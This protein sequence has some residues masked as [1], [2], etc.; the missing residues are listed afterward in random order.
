MAE[1]EKQRGFNTL[2][3]FEPILDRFEAV[4]RAGQRPELGEYL[5]SVSEASRAALFCELLSLEL[6]YR[7]DAGETPQV[8]DYLARFPLFIEPIRQVFA[9]SVADKRPLSRR[10]SS[11]QLGTDRNLLFGIMAL[12]MDFI[13]R[14][15]LIE[16]LRDWTTQKD[17]PLGQILVERGDLSAPRRDLLE[18]LVEEHVRQHDNDPA[19][20][21]ASISSVVDADIDWQNVADADIAA[22]LAARRNSRSAKRT[23][24]VNAEDA[25]SSADRFRVLRPHARGGIGEVFLAFDQE[26]HREVALKEIQSRHVRD[27]SHRERFVREAEVT[28]GLEHPGI[29]PVYSLG[30]YG[31]GRPFYAMR[32]IRGDSLKE[33]IEQFHANRSTGGSPVSIEGKEPAQRADT[34]APTVIGAAPPEAQVASPASDQR[35]PLTT[36]KQFESI[37]FRKLLG[38]F[39]DV[40]QSIEYAHSRGVLHRDLKPGNIM[41]G[42]Y[43][44]TLVVDWGLAKAA[45]KDDR[46]ADSEEATFI[47]SSGSGLEQTQQ[48]SIVGTPSYMSPEQ[49]AGK[50]DQLGPTTDVYSLGATLY[51][52][53][54]GQAPVTAQPRQP[55]AANAPAPPRQSMTELLRRVQHGEFPRPREIISHVPNPLEAVCLK[56]MSLRPQDRYASSAALAE[57]IEHWLADEPLT[58]YRETPLATAS[59]WV[60]KHRAWAMSGAA[61]MALVA[62][63]SSVAAVWI[64]SARATVVSAQK[65]EAKQL[66]IA[67]D[68]ERLAIA[69]QKKAVA[70]AVA[71][72]QQ[73]R[74]AEQETKRAND[75]ADRGRLHLYAARMNLVQS[76]WDEARVGETERLLTLYRP[77]AGQQNHSVELRGFEWFYWDRL[78]RS[79]LLTLDGHVDM[80]REVV[81]STDGKLLA[82]ASEDK[83][84]KVWDAASGREILTLKGHTDGVNSVAFSGDGKRLA[85]A[86]ANFNAAIPGEAKVWDTTS[87]H[88]LFTLKGHTQGVLCVAFRADGKQLATASW[89]Q[90]VK[91]WDAT[92]GQEKLT[93]KG[94]TNCVTRVAFSADGERL[95]SASWDRSVKV[96]NP[97]SGQEMLTLNDHTGNVSSVAFSSDRKRL[98]SATGL[99]A[100]V[101]DATNGEEILTLKG[102][103]EGVN[104]VTFSSDGNRLATASHD[105]TVKVWD[106]TSG[107]ESFTL[108]GHNGPILSVAFN[109]NDDRL[110]SAG[111]DGAVKVWDATSGQETLTFRGHKNGATTLAFSPNGKQI[112]SSGVGATVILW[113]ASSGQ[114]ILSLKGHNGQVMSVAFSADGKRLLSSD[115]RGTMKV[116]DTTSGQET[117]TLNESANR[118]ALSPDGKRLASAGQNG[119]VKMWD[120]TRGLETIKLKGHTS[121]AISV[122]FSADGQWLAS[123]S[124]DQTMKLWNAIS[125][126]ETV[127]LKGHTGLITSVA[128]DSDGKRLASAGQDKTVRV[129]DTTTGQETLTLKGHISWVRSVAFSADGRRLASASDDNTAKV[130]DTT[131]GQ[132]LL[133]LKGHTGG[134]NCVAFSPDGKLMA[135]ASWDGTVKVWGALQ[136]VT[137]AITL[138]A[139]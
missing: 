91:I 33:A 136:G 34:Y 57:D 38:R 2:F 63:V 53:L 117:L 82:S 42:K 39:I 13:G 72:K 36:R 18:P 105:R 113:D 5:T 137:N 139:R 32:F 93:L 106:A 130:W 133:T 135:S 19:A 127:T 129:W 48:G 4:W 1:N 131:T 123:S 102:H 65:A 116:W 97:K 56:A 68:N 41:L 99:T 8:S 69:A 108:K 121:G 84:I 14:D 66:G 49:A 40:C 77:R 30:H 29:V 11:A 110:V 10:S 43:G 46:F 112:A 134:V 122:A 95:A 50:L 107:Q 28:G 45:G 80:V 60:R 16:A 118:S 100:K 12:Q 101:W 81:F 103:A 114:E 92:N 22:S 35:E 70:A 71:E 124:G 111:F 132:E 64:N 86:S 87:G 83:T 59:R 20:S 98:A 89:D 54:T 85:S 138:K 120:T 15:A 55:G 61:A 7:R 6:G 79:D 104:C 62:L 115:L 21:L 51:H 76:R 74:L 125:G 26:L 37:E 52:L 47:P 128:L 119:A 25:T 67:L 90:T 3:E 96:W 94:H 109:P 27:E 31:D 75:E 9:Q 58:A 17:K 126:E 23:A 78:C 24:G 44:E 88:E 73:R